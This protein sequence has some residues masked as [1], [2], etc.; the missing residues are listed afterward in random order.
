MKIKEVILIGS[1]FD[2]TKL[3]KFPIYQVNYANGTHSII[4]N[5]SELKLEKLKRRVVKTG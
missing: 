4:Y 5:P 3:Q 1:K 2:S